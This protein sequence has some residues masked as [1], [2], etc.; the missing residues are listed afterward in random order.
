[1]VLIKPD[2]FC[3]GLVGRI[4]TRLE[5]LMNVEI[6]Q[7]MMF[8]G[9][10]IP[11]LIEEHYEE[12]EGKP[13]YEDLIDFMVGG[14]L[15][16]IEFHGPDVVRKVRDEIGAT[17]PREAQDWTIRGQYRSDEGP[18]HENLVHAS[19]SRDS[20]ERELGLWLEF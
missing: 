14:K 12:H 4:I 1:M 7:M 10:Q 5:N 19:D 2:A 17:N 3:R 9:F 6:L 8:D 16:A 11:D 20:A 13:F 18:V 15:L